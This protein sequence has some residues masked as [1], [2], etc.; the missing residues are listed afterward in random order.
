LTDESLCLNEPA[1][2][3]IES[4]IAK[5]LPV[6]T[7]LNQTRAA[8]QSLETNA[9]KSTSDIRELQ[10]QL[11]AIRGQI[12]SY[13]LQIKSQQLRHNHTQSVLQSIGAVEESARQELNSRTLDLQRIADLMTTAS[14]LRNVTSLIPDVE[15]TPT[16]ANTEESTCDHY[17]FGF[18][19]ETSLISSPVIRVGFNS[20]SIAMWFQKQSEIESFVL[21]DISPLLG[22]GVYFGVQNCSTLTLNFLGKQTLLTHV[23]NLCD[24]PVWHSLVFTWNSIGGEVVVFIDGKFKLRKWGIG[25]QKA[26]PAD[27]VLTIGNFQNHSPHKFVRK[28]FLSAQLNFIIFFFFFFPPP[29]ICCLGYYEQEGLAEFSGAIRDVVVVQGIF[30]PIE[31]L[32]FS[33]RRKYIGSAPYIHWPLDQSTVSHQLLGRP[34]GLIHTIHFLTFSSLAINS[35]YTGNRYCGSRH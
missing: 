22:D 25:A 26:I 34:Q 7:N 17:A 16:V 30:S 33:M 29:L 4:R 31:V 12:E 15:T 1:R 19:D 24:A 23:P 18:D 27:T 3:E 2:V 9:Q 20:F 13:N 14:E 8:I 21:F 10:S 6:S 28:H 32:S 11:V 35:T 5:S